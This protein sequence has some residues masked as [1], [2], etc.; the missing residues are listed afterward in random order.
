MIQYFPKPY[1]PSGGDINVKV[2]LFNYAT[3]KDLKK[4]TGTYTS[5]LTTKSDLASLKAEID[6]GKLKTAP[7][8]L[9]KLGNV[10]RMKLL[11]KL[12]MINWFQKLIILIL[13]DL[14]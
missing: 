9:S 12:C 10:V 1:E 3:K 7:I 14:F 5:N 2:D 13:V 6:V 11:K 8:D 4:A